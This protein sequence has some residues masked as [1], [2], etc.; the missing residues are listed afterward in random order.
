MLTIALAIIVLLIIVR[1]IKCC[2]HRYERVNR[3]YQ[4]IHK[5]I[6]FNLFIRY[7]L[8]STLKVQIATSACIVAIN[9]TGWTGFSVITQ[10]FF[11]IIILIGF[12]LCPLLFIWVMYANSANLEK[13]SIQEKI[14]SMYLGVWLGGKIRYGLSLSIMFLARRSIFVAITFGLYEHPGLQIHLFIFT[15]LL[16]IIY[17]SSFHIY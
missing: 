15:S 9:Q 5:K 6:F 16:Y 7:I 1:L 4:Q 2:I 17:L 12:I 8:Q 11:A 13:D 3:L 14:G 10:G